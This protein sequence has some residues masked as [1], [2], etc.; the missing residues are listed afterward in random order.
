MDRDQALRILRQ[1]EPQ[2]RAAGVEHL[3][4]FGSVAR[5]DQNSGSDVD[6]A[7]LM[8]SSRRWTLFTLGRIYENLRDI[9]GT[10]VD[11]ALL[12]S[13]RPPVAERVAREGVD[14]F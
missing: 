4:L 1:H 12:D 2:L 10:Q 9:L 14:A 5:G 7:L 11:V 3:R 6:V 13:L 8:D